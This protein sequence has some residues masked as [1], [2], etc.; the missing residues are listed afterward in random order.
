MES[1]QKRWLK[2]RSKED[3]LLIL[4]VSKIKILNGVFEFIISVF[5]ITGIFFGVC[6]F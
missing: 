2:T 4:K 1:V 3:A 6:H 5:N